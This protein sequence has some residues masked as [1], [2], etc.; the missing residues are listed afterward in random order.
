MAVTREFVQEQI[1]M[2]EQRLD[3]LRA[4]GNACRGAI[5][6]W[7]IVLAQLEEVPDGRSAP[8]LVQDTPQSPP[9]Q[10]EG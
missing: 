10:A 5:Q 9:A 2:L 3:Q 8:A 1:G 7:R 4:D 6:A